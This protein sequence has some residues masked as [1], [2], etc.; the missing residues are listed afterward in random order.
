MHNTFELFTATAQTASNPI[1]N[2]PGNDIHFI[3][4]DNP[5]LIDTPVFNYKLKIKEKNKQTNKQNNNNISEQ[6]ATINENQINYN[7]NI[8]EKY[9]TVFQHKP[10][11]GYKG[12]GQ[13]AIITETPFEDISTAIVSVLDKK[14][15]TYLT[16]SPINPVGY[17][18]VW[19]SDLNNDNQIFS[20]WSPIPPSGCIALGDIIIMGTEQP[21]LDTVAC[22]PITMLDK[23]ALSNGIIWK[24]DND[25]GKSCYCWG[26]GNIGLFK[27]SNNYSPD[28]PELQTV[29]NLSNTVLI[30]NTLGN[31]QSNNKLASLA[32]LEQQNNGITI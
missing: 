25:M 17:N 21:L 26:A 2:L 18:L 7:E 14:C 5:Q 3:N 27:C 24:S 12:I 1:V 6:F 32:S 30:N 28:M 22:F 9:L 13:Y 15:L 20:V 23:T 19:T 11:N 10:Y 4:D 8:I 31:N 16:S 29:Y